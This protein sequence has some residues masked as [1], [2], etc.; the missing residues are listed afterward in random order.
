MVRPSS[1]VGQVLF[2]D[3][4][5]NLRKIC[6]RPRQGPNFLAKA[7]YRLNCRDTL[8]QFDGLSKEVVSYVAIIRHSFILTVQF[9]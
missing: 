9:R 5:L 4:E 3:F 7:L 6:F 8:G 2:T 1:K